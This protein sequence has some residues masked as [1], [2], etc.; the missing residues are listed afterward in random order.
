LQFP[1]KSPNPCTEIAWGLGKSIDMTE[2]RQGLAPA[3]TPALARTLITKLQSAS[4]PDWAW[5]VGLWALMV[6][7]AVFLR[8]AHLEEGTVLA[9]ARGAVEDGHWLTPHMYGIRFVERPVFLSWLIAAISYPFGSVS[10]WSARIP[11]LLFLLCGGL[12]IFDL[13]RTHATKTA[14]YF[15]VLCWFAAPI[16]AQKVV[17][18]EPD[19]TVSVLLF[20]CFAIWWKGHEA[21]YVSLPRWICIGIV[22]AAAAL[23]KGP[24][25]VAYFTLGVGSFLLLRFQWREIPGF[26]L[27]NAIAGLVVFAWY[28][29][30][31]Q[32][33]DLALWEQ[34]GRMGHITV[35]RWISDHVNLAVSMLFEWMP[36]SMMLIFGA[37]P[38][39]KVLGGSDF[40]VAAALYASACTLVLAFWPGEVATRYAM[41]GTLGLAVVS[42]LLFDRIRTEK[43]KLASAGLIV[44]GAVALYVI[45]VGWIAM[46]LAYNAF[47]HSRL[48]ADQIEAVRPASVPFFVCSASMD[49]NP[50]LYV[51][52]PVSA[53]DCGR[54]L[55]GLPTHAFAAVTEQEAQFIASA[56]PDLKVTERRN[57]GKTSM[58]ILIEIGAE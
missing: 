52:G 49:H 22:L 16:V 56:R 30:V 28:R 27:A 18:A 7:P 26:V 23:T 36:S 4:V 21:G 32:P 35:Q 6:I 45:I 15:A 38:L 42:G 54:Q 1:A 25:P 10:V 47:N 14:S 24:Q 39:R 11:H 50:L 29:A 12:V 43:P 5:V 33:S 58:P 31:F 55:R 20:C 9:L 44:G 17:T 13:V 53:L 2:L 3:T 57:L 51:Q 37:R 19:V 46:P 48:V 8:A 34:H 41:P 40:A